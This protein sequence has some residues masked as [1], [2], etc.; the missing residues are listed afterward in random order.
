MPSIFPNALPLYYFPLILLLSLISAIAGSLLSQPTDIEV[1]KNFYKN[2][3]PWGYWGVIHEA[4]LK[5]DPTFEANKNFKRDMFNVL[6][7]TIGQTAITALP[8]FMVLLM[9]IQS[10]I[11]ALILGVCMI[12]LWKTWYQKLPTS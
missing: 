6:I 10:I 9:P 11:T 12:I 3:R 2:V 1:L 4:V 7:G 5:E 8:V